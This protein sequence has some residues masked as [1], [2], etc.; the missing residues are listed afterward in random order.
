MSG[1]FIERNQTVAL[2]L[3]QSDKS[4]LEQK[5]CGLTSSHMKSE[6]LK[7]INEHKIL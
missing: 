1:N 6:I 4:L 7:S 3:L 5:S 2:R